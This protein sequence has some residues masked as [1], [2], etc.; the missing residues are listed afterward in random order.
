MIPLPATTGYGCRW[1]A[2]PPHGYNVIPPSTYPRVV[3]D[4]R[5]DGGL[6]SPDSGGRCPCIDDIAVSR[7]R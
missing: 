6:I 4:G 7:W 3:D 1:Y 5:A 2:A